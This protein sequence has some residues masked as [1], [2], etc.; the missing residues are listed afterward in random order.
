MLN[1][2][3][4]VFT[5]SPSLVNAWPN[6]SHAQTTRALLCRPLSFEWALI[7][8][9]TKR[10]HILFKQQWVHGH[11]NNINNERADRLANKANLLPTTTLDYPSIWLV[12][13]G[14]LRLACDPTKYVKHLMSRY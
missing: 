7:L 4:R 11:D 1:R 9:L 3:L 6:V 5:D 13:T 12:F 2:T 10:K 14:G 8:S